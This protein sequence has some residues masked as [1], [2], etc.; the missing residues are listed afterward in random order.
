MLSSV[1]GEWL[2][3]WLV[4]SQCRPCEHVLHLLLLL[5]MRTPADQRGSQVVIS[6]PFSFFEEGGS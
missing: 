1:L 2:V 3:Y 6:Q 5:L 4:D